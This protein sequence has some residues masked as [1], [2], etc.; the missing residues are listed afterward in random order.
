M[1]RESA[2][3]NRPGYGGACTQRGFKVV[4][5]YDDPVWLALTGATGIGPL[6]VAQAELD[7]MLAV[8]GDDAA[9]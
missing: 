9:A 8:A 6:T 1:M 2:P 5:L 4:E 7:G 3:Q